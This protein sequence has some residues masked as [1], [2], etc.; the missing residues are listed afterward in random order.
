MKILF[1]IL[2]AASL[3]AN[4]LL[5]AALVAGHHEAR[6]ATAAAVKAPAPAS[7]PKPAFDGQ[8]WT[9]LQADDL[10]ALLQRLR[11]QGFPIEIIRAILAAQ[12]RAAYA[13][14]MKA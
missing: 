14:R 4:V 1:R 7:A 13:E 8:T 3:L 12:L 10:P 11:A 6:P 9:T 5:L 2:T